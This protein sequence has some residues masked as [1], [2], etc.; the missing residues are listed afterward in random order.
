M[1]TGKTGKGER[2]GSSRALWISPFWFDGFSEYNSCHWRVAALLYPE[3]Q[4]YGEGKLLPLRHF[5]FVA[6]GIL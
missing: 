3:N 2:A 4:P 5:K 6:P 1:L